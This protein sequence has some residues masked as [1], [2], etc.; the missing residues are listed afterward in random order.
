MAFSL[1]HT[2]WPTRFFAKWLA[3]FFGASLCGIVLS[4][5][6]H[7]HP[8]PK[9]ALLTRVQINLRAVEVYADGTRAAVP[10]L[11]STG[12]TGD[13]P[14]PESD[15]GTLSTDAKK[16]TAISRVPGSK[17]WLIFQWQRHSEPRLINPWPQSKITYQVEFR[18]N[19]PHPPRVLPPRVLPPR[20]LPPR[21]S[22]A[23][24]PPAEH[25]H[26]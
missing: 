16:P 23:A 3:L 6:V 15:Q 17:L 24:R 2:C 7:R 21:F 10:A 18:L 14:V 12:G 19:R 5:F 26:A 25:S 8:A 20:V 22:P 11:L 4:A 13:K 9:P 1:A